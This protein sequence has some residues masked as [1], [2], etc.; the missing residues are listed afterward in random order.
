M[1]MVDGDDFKPGAQ[2]SKEEDAAAIL[3]SLIRKCLD[4][5]NCLISILFAWLVYL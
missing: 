5:L 3:M 1:K 4:K 2:D